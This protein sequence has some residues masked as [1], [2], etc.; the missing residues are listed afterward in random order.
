[1]KIIQILPELNSGGVERGTCEIAEHLVKQGHESLVI[2]H[3]GRLVDQL[4]TSGSRHISLPI[5]RKHPSSLLQLPSLRSIFLSE[6]PDLIHLRSRL[7]AW[8]AYFAWRSLPSRQRPHLMTTVHGF[9]S[10]NSYSSIMTKGQTVICVSHSIKEQILR[11]YPK[12][13]A[14]KLHVI[15]RGVNPALYNPGYRPSSE[16]LSAWNDAHP[17]LKD[18]K[19]LL[20]PGRIT[21]L[22]GHEEFFSL[23]R[24]L[25]QKG[26]PAHGLIVGDTHPN[27]RSYLAELHNLINTLGLRPHITFLGHRSDLR[28]IIAVTDITYSMSRKPE[29]FGR[30]ALEAVALAK[31]TIGHAIGGVNEILT[32]CFPQGLVPLHDKQA[33]YTTTLQV[34]QN[35]TVPREIPYSFTLSAMCDSTLALYNL[36]TR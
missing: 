19:I 10:V 27:K 30:T 20:L 16:W 22:K 35:P 11:N 17:Y 6:K 3:G 8:I 14:S 18:Q 24:D 34:L 28:D 36:Q 21:R 2:S 1:M 33:L 12:I 31:P 26:T 7:P 25:R 23:I 32:A 9:H 13:D 29:S 4:Q 15:H 5:H